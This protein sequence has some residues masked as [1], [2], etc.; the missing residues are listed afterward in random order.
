MFKNKSQKQD[1]YVYEKLKKDAQN[2]LSTFN[3]T[4]IESMESRIGLEDFKKLLDELNFISIEK[5]TP[6]EIENIQDL[7]T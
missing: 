6:T 1:K 7:W 3:I 2:F 4:D 5:P